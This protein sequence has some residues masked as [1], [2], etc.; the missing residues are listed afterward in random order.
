MARSNPTRSC[1]QVPCVIAIAFFAIAA[2]L[3]TLDSAAAAEPG[4]FTIEA[5]VRGA[6][7]EGTPLA[8]SEQRIFLL[9]R[10]G[11]LTEFSPNEAVDYHKRSP[12]FRPYAAGVMRSRLET[13]LGRAYEV[14]AT[15]HYLVAYPRG[16]R[17]QW[18]ERFEEMYRAFAAYFSVRGFTLQQPQFPL[19]AIVWNRK[20]DFQK[21]AIKEGSKLP[22]NVLGYY[23][24][25]SNR[26][27][28]YDIAA[29][30][31]DA[32]DWRQNASTVLHEAAHQTAFNTGIH[33]RFGDV[34]KWVCEGLAT[35]FEARG[36]WN[37]RTY[38]NLHDR[39]N[40]D[41]LDQFREYLKTRRKADSLAQLIAS[42]R[43]FDT[44]SAAGY[45]EA[46][47]FT[48]FLVET[49]PREYA[50]Y[51]ALTAARPPFAKYTSQDRVKDF[52]AVFGADFRMID[53]RFLR[54]IEGLK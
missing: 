14:T 32:A 47:A 23:S 24:P 29:G 15:G 36:V 35:L 53:A 7:L 27:T 16:Q 37:S 48:F 38:T 33:N 30:K 41:R 3:S 6:R 8:W 4:K 11:A 20:E 31:S 10:D 43:V 45:S 17:D 21:Y 22:S 44:D 1:R 51:L 28:L 12:D 49:Q 2:G 34:P 26:V 54:Y 50:K 5:V 40:R 39:L 13:E 52:A 42:D 18:A 9:G 25:T 19:I 46:W